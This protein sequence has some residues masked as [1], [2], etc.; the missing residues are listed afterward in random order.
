MSTAV[1]LAVP[2]VRCDGNLEK[3]EKCGP[4]KS[5]EEIFRG[6]SGQWVPVVGMLVWGF[7]DVSPGMSRVG[8][9]ARICSVNGDG[10]LEVHW[11]QRTK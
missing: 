11:V 7:Q 2:A 1:Q 3:K 6:F 8:G 5:P 9:E 10:E 4:T